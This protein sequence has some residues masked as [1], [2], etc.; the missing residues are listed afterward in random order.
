LQPPSQTK[1]ELL[2]EK[3]ELRRAELSRRVP[4]IRWLADYDRLPVEGEHILMPLSAIPDLVVRAFV[5]AQDPD[6]YSRNEVELTYSTSSISRRITAQ[7]YFPTNEIVSLCGDLSP[8]EQRNVEIAAKHVLLEE[9]VVKAFSKPQILEIFL[10]RVWL[11][12]RIFGA[13][14]A[15]RHYFGKPIQALELH[16]AAYLAALV[17]YQ[18]QPDLAGKADAALAARNAV[19][20]RMAE[21]GH[22]DLKAATEASSKPLG[23]VLVADGAK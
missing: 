13:A 19:L 20:Q 1:E 22:I 14:A 23:S 12:S 15:A 21:Q 18:S 16:E 5:V 8:E 10:N 11:G 9:S 7:L 17:K 6:F 2:R 4:D 3:L